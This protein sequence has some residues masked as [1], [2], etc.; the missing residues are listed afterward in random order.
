MPNADLLR[1]CKTNRRRRHLNC[2]IYSFRY[3]DV[4]QRLELINFIKS[5]N[6]QKCQ[7]PLFYSMTM[8]HKQVEHFFLLHKL[9]FK[10]IYNTYKNAT[11]FIELENNLKRQL[12]VHYEFIH[13]IMFA[14]EQKNF[15]ISFSIKKN[16]KKAQTASSHTLQSS[17]LNRVNRLGD[18]CNCVLI[19]IF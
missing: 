3:F 2:F 16:N 15:F 19:T 13:S 17:L 18:M 11:S 7:W 14:N 1:N 8:I 6:V 12:C 9:T 5:K 10:R 4:F